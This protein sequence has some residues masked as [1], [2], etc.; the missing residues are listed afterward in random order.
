MPAVSRKGDVHKTGHPC[1][2]FAKLAPPLG[3]GTVFANFKLMCRIRD[4]D[5]PHTILIGIK[6]V[7]HV[8]PLAH[9]H[10]RVIVAGKFQ[11]TIGSAIDLGTMVT[12]SPTVFVGGGSAGAWSAQGN[13]GGASLSDVGAGSKYA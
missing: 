8:V 11:S 10:A 3:N 4:P 1:A 5:V 7:P 2:P 6:C 12:G 13:A 9:G